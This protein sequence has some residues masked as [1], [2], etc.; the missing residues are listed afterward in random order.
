MS[1]IRALTAKD[2]PG[3]ARLFLKTFR[4]GA[5]E[6][7]AAMIGYFRRHY[8]ESPGYDPQI[9]PLV[10][11]R[12]DGTIGGFIG[13]HAVPM[14]LRDRPLRAAICGAFMVEGHE[15][16]PFAG[17]RLVKTLLSGPQDLTFSETANDISHAIWQR[18]RGLALPAYSL[19]WLRVLR[20]AG[21][22]V[23]KLGRRLPLAARLAAPL[24][25]PLDRFQLGRM[26]NDRPHWSGVPLKRAP[27][28]GV[29]V[30]IV[31]PDF[32]AGTFAE[33]VE[34]FA[35]RP[36]FSE[37]QRRHILAEATQPRASG[38]ARLAAVRDRSGRLIGLFLGHWRAG[39]T[40][41]I[42]QILARPGQ[43][44]TVLDAMIDHVAGEGA[45]A[46]SG[47]T[48]PALLEAMLGRRIA[49]LHFSS[50]VVHARDEAILE[51]FR[52]GEA[53]VNGL[54]GERWSS[55]VEGSFGG[56]AAGG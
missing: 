32:F 49:F 23:E 4:N 9:G 13:V 44:G 25:R 27:L 8:L 47:R 56:S 20:P 26:G 22:M 41:E 5:G 18:L 15:Q 45:V 12:D 16:D 54:V 53:F 19:D 35:L 43:A 50:T 52:R 28:P 30:E 31:T 1:E 3:V 39:S 21:F 46:V 11:E 40:A 33:L 6:P 29:S 36:N 17:A 34:S 10:I 38:E 2:I 55:L 7:S 37:A 51:A 24:A 42:L 14:R 48:Q